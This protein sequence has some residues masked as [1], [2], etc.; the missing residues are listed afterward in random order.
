MKFTL[1]ALISVATAVR[2]QGGPSNKELNAIFK[3]LDTSKDGLLQEGEVVAGLVELAKENNHVITQADKDWLEA[4]AEKDNK[5]GNDS[6]NK[7]EFRA[8]ARAVAKHYDL[9]QD[10]DLDNFLDEAFEHVDTNG[11]GSISRKEFKTAIIEL[12]GL[13]NHKITPKDK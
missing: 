12:A 9:A 2:L 13:L 7:K 3:Q 10:D 5:D 4:E 6:F 11:N 1:I 8:F